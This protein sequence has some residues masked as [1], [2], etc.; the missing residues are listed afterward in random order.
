MLKVSIVQQ[1]AW[2]IPMDSVPLA[3]GYLKAMAAADEVL[4]GET[5]VNIC[6]FRGGVALPKMACRLFSADIPDILAFS[7]L[8]WNYRNFVCL[9]ETYKQLRPDGLVVFGGNHVSRQA[10]KVFREAPAVDVVVNGEGERTFRELV[11]AVLAAPTASDLSGVTGLSYR[12]ADGAVQT[13]AERDRIEDLDEVP[14]PLLA[15]AIPMADATGR[16]PYEFA[17]LETNRG[18]PYKCAFCYWGGAVGQ[19]VR[20]FSRERLAEELDLFGYYQVPTVFLCDANFEMLDADEEFVEDLV[21][22]RERYGFPQALEA[23][24]AKNK[25]AR[26]HRIVTMLKRHRLNSS[27]T[28]ALRTLTDEALDGMQR[29]NMKINQ[30]EG[31]VDWLAGEGLDCY[32]E[33]IWGAPGD[34]PSSFLH[35]YDR[36]AERVPR[37]AM[38]PMLLLPNTG[39]T[40]QRERHGFATIRGEHDD[41]EYVLANHSVGLSEHLRMQRFM[42]LARL[43]SEN[44]YFK[45]LW[46]PARRLAGMSQ[47]QVITS[48]LEWLDTSHF[49]A[50][51]QFRESFPVIAESP[52]VAAGHRLLYSRPELDAEIQR[53]WREVVV[54]R[55][56]PQWRDFGRQI[57][58]Y[59]RWARPVY[60]PPGTPIPSGW[61]LQDGLYVSDLVQLD[62]S[63][64][65]TL[66]QLDGSPLPSP[67]RSPVTYRFRSSVGF[68]NHLDNHETGAH[69]F[70]VPRIASQMEDTTKWPRVSHAARQPV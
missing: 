58:I 54:E 59:E 47:S 46:K 14:S 12:G 49:S 13:T 63:I 30:W 10:T 60:H 39:Y 61:T 3:A 38:Y 43:L 34:T 31:L 44:Q 67:R 18:C 53:W 48:L 55:F 17:L 6:N 57:Y 4:A 65:H 69:Y 42:Y 35:G 7:V 26:V 45:R 70:A 16:F 28:L 24:Y 27:F 40:Q 56:P 19:R 41:F 11:T 52:A 22:A 9:A 2:D 21:R 1:S 8:G 15:G 29:R 64:E 37:I 62:Y 23:N 33:L 68:Y 20:S 50:V 32:A 5:E 36:L 51:Q 25:S 66:S